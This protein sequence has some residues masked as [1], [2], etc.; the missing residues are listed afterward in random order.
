MP[1]ERK[2]RKTV[3]KIVVLSEDDGEFDPEDDD[4]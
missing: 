1:S 4:G 3:I 2:F